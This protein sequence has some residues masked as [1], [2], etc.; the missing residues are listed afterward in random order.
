MT[1]TAT[2]TVPLIGNQ[3]A[4]IDLVLRILLAQDATNLSSHVEICRLNT[5]TNG[6]S[7]LV[8]FPATV[9]ALLT[10]DQTIP[11]PVVN[12]G[13]PVPVPAFSIVVGQ[14]AAG[15]PVDDDA[16]GND[17]VTISTVLAGTNIMAFAGF[18]IELSF[19]SA[20]LTDASTLTGDA[21]FTTS[22][23][24]FDTV[25]LGLSGPISVTPTSPTT[26]FTSTKLAGDVPCSDVLALFP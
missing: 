20:T 15:N 4:T 6:N 18:D 22:G 19:P 26:A 14:D 24:V 8:N 7:L 21:A 13:D 1:T 11:A 9:L 3:P 12:V 17:G 5:A 2:L 23:T 25:P 10:D 16:D